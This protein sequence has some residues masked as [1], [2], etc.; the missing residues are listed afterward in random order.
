MRQLLN[1][2]IGYPAHKVASSL[3]DERVVTNSV[4]LVAYARLAKGNQENVRCRHEVLV[5][6]R[7]Q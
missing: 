4:V 2:V 6:E 1:A 3:G 5:L 7:E